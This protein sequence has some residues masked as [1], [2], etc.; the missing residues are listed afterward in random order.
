MPTDT[1]QLNQELLTALQSDPQYNYDSELAGGS[2]SLLEWLRRVI[3]EWINNQFDVVLEDDVV[4]YILI[5]MG[6]LLV[7]FLAYLYWRFRPKLFVRGGNE[8]DI[9]YDVQEDT[10]YGVDFEADIAKAL[11]DNDYRQAVRLIYLQTLLHLQNAS[12]IDWQPSKTPVQYMRQVNNP[13]FT[14][15][16]HHF[17]RVR[18]GNFEASKELFDE[19]KELQS[20]LSPLTA[21]PSPLVPHE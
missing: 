18:Y 7:L 1:L 2:E 5:G 8:D 3:I 6:A 21:H 17:V 14:A 19:M 11:R 10:I 16:S 12:L 20:A 9:P 4:N 13:A 15:M